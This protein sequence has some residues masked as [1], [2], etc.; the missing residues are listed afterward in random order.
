[1]LIE[2][3]DLHVRCFLVHECERFGLDDDP[4]K[5]YLFNNVYNLNCFMMC[6]Q[7]MEED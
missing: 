7:F 3:G 2:V 5:A 4:F 6:E 1:M